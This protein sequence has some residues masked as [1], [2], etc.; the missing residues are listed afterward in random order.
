MVLLSVGVFVYRK[1]QTRAQEDSVASNK[2]HK[3][4]SEHRTTTEAWRCWSE[5][6][7]E[8]RAA[9]RSEDVAFWIC[10]S[11]I[12]TRYKGGPLVGTESTAV[13]PGVGTKSI[14]GHTGDC[15]TPVDLSKMSVTKLGRA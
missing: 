14:T 1:R 12:E 2:E 11:N 10:C 4:P 9:L 8:R 15:A 13:G 5:S 3:V 6:S 7:V